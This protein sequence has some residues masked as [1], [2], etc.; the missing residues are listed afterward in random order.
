MKAKISNLEVKIRYFFIYFFFFFFFWKLAFLWKK[1]KNK[2]KKEATNYQKIIE[3][4]EK[5]GIVKTQ[6]TKP[7]GPDVFIIFYWVY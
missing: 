7:T 2:I 6:V 3:E 1:L 4:I 5:N